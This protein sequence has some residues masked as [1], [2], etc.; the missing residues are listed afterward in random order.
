MTTT[1][2]QLS[3]TY[4]YKEISS[5]GAGRTPLWGGGWTALCAR[6]LGRKRSAPAER[7]QPGPPIRCGDTRPNHQGAARS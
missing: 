7:A 4:R 6:A 1:S 2:L 3:A 5:V